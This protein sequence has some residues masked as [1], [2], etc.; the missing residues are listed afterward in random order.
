MEQGGGGRL[1]VLQRL[2]RVGQQ[3]AGKLR[4]VGEAQA[5][6]H[7]RVDGGHGRRCG[8]A[9]AVQRGGLLLL[10]LG[11]LLLLLLMLLLL[12]LLLVVQH[13]GGSGRHRGGTTALLLLVG[14]FG[15]F[16]EQ[17]PNKNPTSTSLLLLALLS[18]FFWYLVFVLV[19]YYFGIFQ[20]QF[21]LAIDLIIFSH[22]FLFS[23][24]QF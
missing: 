18:C 10:L 3:V 11:R 21:L 1:P 12:L 8:G 24:F 6:V 20:F 14:R 7:A 17:T 4:L 2:Q 15:R 19:R 5:A 9:A 13:G 22:F 23:K 16:L